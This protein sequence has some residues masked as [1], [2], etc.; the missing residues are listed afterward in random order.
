MSISGCLGLGV[1][2]ERIH[3]WTGRIFWGNLNALKFEVVMIDHCREYWV[4]GR[5]TL[6]VVYNFSQQKYFKAI[7]FSKLRTRFSEIL[8]QKY[9]ARR[10]FYHNILLKN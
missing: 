8:T 10:L 6:E 5:G 7:V 1:G 2:K 3:K 4:P 9:V